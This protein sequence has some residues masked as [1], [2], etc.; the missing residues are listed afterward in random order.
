MNRVIWNSIIDNHDVIE[1]DDLSD[2]W[3]ELEERLKD[4]LEKNTIYQIL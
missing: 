2:I 1:L 3:T 4:D